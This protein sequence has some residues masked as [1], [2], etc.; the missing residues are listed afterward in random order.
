MKRQKDHEKKMMMA[1][2]DHLKEDAS[3]HLLKVSAN[4]LKEQAREVFQAFVTEELDTWQQHLREGLETLTVQAAAS[5]SRRPPSLL[6][7][8]F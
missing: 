1:A 8:P 6:L 7:F 4:K 5:L 2:D 3:F